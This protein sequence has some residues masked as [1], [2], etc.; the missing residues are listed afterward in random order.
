MYFLISLLF[1]LPTLIQP[2]KVMA[3]LIV[4]FKYFVGHC[5]SRLKNPQHAHEYMPLL[6]NYLLLN[7]S[8]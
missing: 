2:P 8:L 3:L 7:V 1:L 6:I 4:K 5:A